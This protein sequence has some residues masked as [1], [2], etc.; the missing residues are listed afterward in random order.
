MGYAFRVG[1]PG[2]ERAWSALETQP[3]ISRPRWGGGGGG[4]RHVVRRLRLSG[5]ER[6][7]RTSDGSLGGSEKEGGSWEAVQ[8]VSG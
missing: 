1:A 3:E 2:P 7:L 5:T 8:L 4:G 6:G